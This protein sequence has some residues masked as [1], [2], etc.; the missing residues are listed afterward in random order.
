MSE[1]DSHVMPEASNGGSG[2][3]AGSVARTLR[4]RLPTILLT[5]IVVAAAVGAYGYHS[6]DNYKSTATLLFGQTVGPE[7]NALGLLPVAT[8]APSLIAN[9]TAQVASHNVAQA[10]ATAMGP[11]YTADSVA[12]HVSVVQGKAGDLV[13]VTA[14]THPAT[15]AAKLANT[16][17]QA[18]IATIQAPLR[19]RAART[20]LA[21]TAQIHRLSPR[22]QLNAVGGS[23][24]IKIAQLRALQK[25]GTNIP[26]VVQSGFVPTSRSDK[27]TELIALGVALGLLLGIGLALLREQAD[28]RLRQPAEVSDAFGA[29]VL[30]TIPNDKKLAT[31]RVDTLE[32][33]TVE[34]IQM[35][36]ANLRY[37]FDQT[38]RKLI[39]TSSKGREGKSTIAWNLAVASAASGLKV[40]VLDA[41]LRRSGLA[42]RYG[43]EPRPG[44][45]EVL[46]G[47]T[48]VAR[49]LQ[50]VAFNSQEAG[51]GSGSA[52]G[53]GQDSARQSIDVLIAGAAHSEPAL[54]LQ[55]PE[56]SDLLEQLGRLYDLVIIDTPPIVQVADA[57]AL[58]RGVDGVLLVASV[59]DTSGAEAAA[60]RSQ[61]IALDARVLGIA[62]NRTPRTRGY[63]SAYVSQPA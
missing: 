4:R 21:L 25:V 30:A 50:T 11:G 44:L 6:R 53:A 10:T 12:S 20:A 17:A 36:Q 47:T 7:L 39:V 24:R 41:D 8:D 26:E 5:T 23:L 52:N 33:A 29:R 32:R 40:L 2:T 61:L 18:A 38:P 43:L 31:G 37:G 3:R 48:T 56:M 13:D 51:N 59:R 19:A 16:Y 27:L 63:S 42:A 34:A 9:D 57:I 49:A 62:V 45:S 28:Q 58:L 54:L 15:L 60:V 22:D 14:T 35:L 46:G 55:S 1:Y